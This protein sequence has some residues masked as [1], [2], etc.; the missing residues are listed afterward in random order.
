MYAKLMPKKM[1]VLEKKTKI[2]SARAH[3][4]HTQKDM[5]LTKITFRSNI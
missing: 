1:R 5:V 3:I 4:E 2:T